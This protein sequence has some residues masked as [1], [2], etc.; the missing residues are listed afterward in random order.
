MQNAYTKRSLRH[1]SK[2]WE[3]ETRK[4]PLEL[5]HYIAYHFFQLTRAERE[6]IQ[7]QRKLKVED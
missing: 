1:W 2:F 4:E 6:G 3:K 7:G 5:A